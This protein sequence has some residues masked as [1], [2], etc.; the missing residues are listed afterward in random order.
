SGPVADEAF[1]A[2]AAAIVAAVRGGCDAV[3]LDLHGAMVTD[4]FDDGEGELLSRIRAV[5]PDAPIGVALDLH[6][7]ITR[8]MIE[9][10][11]IMVSFK[12]YP[13][14]DMVETGA[15]VARLVEKMV[16]TGRRPAQAW[17]HPPQLA[18]TLKM[19]TGAPGPMRDVIAAATE[20]ERMPG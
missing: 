18:H 12:T 14:V 9:N 15:H 10:S 16:A 6:G 13:H 1:E 7:N 17:C 4:S 20:A 5:A 3:L 2:M 8:R 19:R 11:D